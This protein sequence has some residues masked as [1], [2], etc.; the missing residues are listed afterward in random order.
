MWKTSATCRLN[1]GEVALEI[2]VAGSDASAEF[3]L[4]CSFAQQCRYV[5]RC[6]WQV[7]L[8]SV[9]QDNDILAFCFLIPFGLAVVLLQCLRLC[10]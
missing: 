9:Q 3:V 10:Q 5:Q 8:A 2:W 6:I 1:S 7:Q 4:R